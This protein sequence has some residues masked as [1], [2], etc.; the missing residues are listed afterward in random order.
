[1][2]MITQVTKEMFID[3][4][5]AMRPDNFSYEGLCALYDYLI[6]QEEAEVAEELD[7]IGICLSYCQYNSLEDY[8]KEHTEQCSTIDEVKKFTS[9]ITLTNG[10]FIIVIF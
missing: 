7:V 4:F 5:K 3:R 10:A 6:K 1:M 9:V 2:Y 8:N